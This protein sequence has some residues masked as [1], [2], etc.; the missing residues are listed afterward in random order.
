MAANPWLDNYMSSG[1]YQNY[2]GGGGGGGSRAQLASI[3]GGSESTTP[4]K[5]GN[6]LTRNLD[7]IGGIGGGI[8]GGAAGGALAGTAVLPGV[9]TVIGGL[10]GGVLGAIGGGGAGKY[11]SQ[12]LQGDQT[13]WG[14]IRNA[15]A[16]NGAGELLGGGI[17]S[18]AGKIGG[19]VIPS[20][21]TR[22]TGKTGDLPF[23]KAV[24]S[25]T[26]F[27]EGRSQKA[28]A[29]QM[30]SNLPDHALNN[31]FDVSKLYNQA[32]VARHIG[33][34][35]HDLRDKAAGLVTGETGFVNTL[36]KNI[37]D[38]SG[39][40][41]ILDNLGTV[42]EDI[43]TRNSLLG[44]SKKAFKEQVRGE[45]DKAIGPK[46]AVGDM[47]ITASKAFKAMQALQSKA[48]DLKLS[49]PKLAGALNEAAR[50]IG[51]MVENDAGVNKAI[52]AFKVSPEVAQQFTAKAIAKLGKDKGQRLANY[53]IDNV[54]AATRLSTNPEKMG[55]MSLRKIEGM[56]VPGSTAATNSEIR[57]LQSANPSTAEQV[58]GSTVSPLGRLGLAKMIGQKVAG[59]E[60]PLAGKA[61]RVVGAIGNGIEDVTG[62]MGN[63]AGGTG[64][65]IP[66]IAQRGAGQILSHGAAPALAEGDQ[67][68]GGQ[69]PLDT[70]AEQI[71]NP[72]DIN[73]DQS[74]NGTTP[75]MDDTNPYGIENLM[76][77][78]RR[79]PKHQAD[80]LKLYTTLNPNGGAGSKLSSTQQRDLSNVRAGRSALQELEQLY[81]QAGG[82]KGRVGGGLENMTGAA[83]WN[84]SVKAYND[85]R[86]ALMSKIARAAGETGTLT[87]QD[88]SRIRK[89][90]PSFT[91]NPQEVKAKLQAL[92][93]LFDQNE[94]NIQDSA[95]ATTQ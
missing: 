61:S 65:L 76:A 27:L 11:A 2:S 20:V 91:D 53:V 88:I 92:Y 57:G 82:G 55:E 66:D 8:A 51:D 72:N 79:D 41:P 32:D 29:K 1:A 19:K 17:G 71:G 14:D 5:K 18:I 63:M 85:T 42:T 28:I 90:L 83:G 16:T 43:A 37:L 62:P 54:N 84:S 30:A 12:K 31:Q 23:R 24:P 45:V 38:N 40:V 3:G 77:D 78:I 49:E 56:F 10:A 94:A 33:L 35:S 34:Y 7:L 60:A 6:V 39:H 13:N 89:G 26:E 4:P 69:P 86:D 47:T 68:N 44:A 9:G 80:Y 75:S 74:G 67:G 87:D 46:G 64:G 81:G 25:A 52:T 48:A 58:A 70:T 21:A 95:M 22:I 93:D 50:H 36:K 73:F 15:A 59:M